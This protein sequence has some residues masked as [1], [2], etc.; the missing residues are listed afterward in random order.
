[1]CQRGIDIHTIS[2]V[3]TVCNH[4]EKRNHGD[5]CNHGDECDH[6]GKH[7]HFDVDILD[8]EH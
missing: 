5:K 3:S 6:G 4:G 7:N 1:M 8:N 2:R